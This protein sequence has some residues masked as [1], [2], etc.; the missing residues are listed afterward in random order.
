MPHSEPV[1]DTFDTTDNPP[2]REFGT[3]KKAVSRFLNPALYVLATGIGAVGIYAGLQTLQPQKPPPMSVE[4]MLKV[5]KQIDERTPLNQAKNETPSK[6]TPVDPERMEASSIPSETPASGV[7]APVSINGVTPSGSP[8]FVQAPAPAPAALSV[9]QKLANLTT[10][11]ENLI[12]R[13]EKAE[14]V[15][16]AMEK[17][18]SQPV[19]LANP[20]PNMQPKPALV[21]A[22][23]PTPK[24]AP[25]SPAR[26]AAVAN[27]QQSTGEEFVP[28]KPKGEDFV[29]L[30]IVEANSNN[31][32]VKDA[33]QK[34]YTVAPGAKLP[35]G[36]VFIAFEPKTRTLRTDVGDFK[37]P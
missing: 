23:N 3:P 18:V 12:A 25:V 31:L 24:P 13:L 2:F 37:L 27:S 28:Q 29:A 19:K 30:T 15:L 1:A 7:P 9:D 14:A 4:D 34:Q 21:A 32:V 36:A 8:G 17:K 6:E 10:A 22:S 11:T 26:P 20:A 5:K 35:G 33:Q 16:D